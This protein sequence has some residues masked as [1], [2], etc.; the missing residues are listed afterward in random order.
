MSQKT[1]DNTNTRATGVKYVFNYIFLVN[2]FF[3]SELLIEKIVY[4]LADS[5]NKTKFKNFLNEFTKSIIKAKKF[6]DICIEIQTFLFLNEKF[7]NV[8]ERFLARLHIQLRY[9][10]FSK[11]Y[12]NLLKLII[13]T[14]PLISFVIY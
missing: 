5:N 13:Y 8:N 4:Y 12:V 3:F 9:L 14:D 2:K 6:G 11:N 7:Y 1:Y 10:R